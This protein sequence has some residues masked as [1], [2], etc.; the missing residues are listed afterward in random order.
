MTDYGRALLNA[1]QLKFM[2]LK[3]S[4]RTHRTIVCCFYGENE[5]LINGKGRMVMVMVMVVMMCQG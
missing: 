3:K 5:N 1:F 4:F 2:M